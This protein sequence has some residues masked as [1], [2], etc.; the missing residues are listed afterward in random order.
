MIHTLGP[1]AGVDALCA[2]AAGIRN[3]S[4]KSYV[5]GQQLL[6]G[7]DYGTIWVERHAE[8]YGGFA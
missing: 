5:V 7:F 2:I 3:A 1:A 4:D 6:S 8:D